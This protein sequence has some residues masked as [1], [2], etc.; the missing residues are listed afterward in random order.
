[1]T[2]ELFDKLRL[3][4]KLSYLKR[5]IK[6]QELLEKHENN[7]SLRMRTFEMYIKP[8]LR[9]SYQTFYNMMNES[10]PRIRIEKLELEIAALTS[11]NNKDTEIKNIKMQHI[12]KSLLT[13]DNDINSNV[14]SVVSSVIEFEE[15]TPQLHVISGSVIPSDGGW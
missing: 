5:C 9:C 13:N 10:N 15:Q 7:C 14:D 11:T 12:N 3:S 1:M 4:R 6:A 8:E 2:Q